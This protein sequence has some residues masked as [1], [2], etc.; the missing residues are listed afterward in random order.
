MKRINMIYKYTFVLISVLIL[1]SCE[2]QEQVL[3]DNESDQM[4]DSTLTGVYS[5]FVDTDEVVPETWVYIM[6]GQSNMAGRGEIEFID[7]ITNERVQAIN[8]FGELILAKEPIHFYEPNAAGVDCGL[9]F[10]NHMLDNVPDNVT[11]L[12]IPTAVGGT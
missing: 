7:T 3:E 12:M 9:S 8:E 5:V 1:S 4:T 2:K 6:A 10:G 11:I